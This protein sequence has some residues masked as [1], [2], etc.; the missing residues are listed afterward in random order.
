MSQIDL[1]RL[2]SVKTIYSHSFCPDG[3][4]AAMICK[5]A[6]ASV[7][8]SP[9]II[10]I[11]YDTSE[12][13]NMEP[14]PNQLFI[15]ITPPIKRWEEWKSFSPIVL[16]HHETAKRAAEEL[17][18]YGDVN[19]SGA[20][21][22]FKHVMK[23][24]FPIEKYRNDLKLEDWARFAWLNMIRDTWKDKHADWRDA[25]SLAQALGFYSSNSLLISANELELNLVEMLRFGGVLLKKCEGKAFRLANTAII[26]VNRGKKF[27]FFNCT[28]K[29]I[30]ET[31]HELIDVHDC[32][33]AVGFFMNLEDGS[34]NI[35]VSLRSK[36]Q[37]VPV[38]KM[39]EILGGGGHP[40]SAGFR[41]K[42]AEQVSFTSLKNQIYDLYAKISE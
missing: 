28:E 32:D 25:C 16:D 31:A 36:K 1:E 18:V 21:L 24:L 9:E 23:P 22:A 42:N 3:L 12:H 11:Q 40:P 34:Y 35:H 2:K 41:L 15:D 26:E 5:A 8:L 33:V 30:N 39:A 20:S 4:S 13:E 7:G 14:G 29:L 37:G 19:D 38:N 17:G 10:F 27:G 6:Y